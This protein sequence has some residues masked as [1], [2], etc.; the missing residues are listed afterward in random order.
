MALPD[1]TPVVSDSTPTFGDNFTEVLGDGRVTFRPKM[2]RLV[3][4]RLL[5]EIK[6]LNPDTA[7]AQQRWE[8]YAILT[9]WPVPEIIRLLGSP[10]SEGGR[11]RQSAQYLD[12]LT[13]QERSSYAPGTVR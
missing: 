6:R 4:R 2:V 5:S 8:W 10:D 12:L 1:A 11:L 7:S 3:A 13:S 9:L